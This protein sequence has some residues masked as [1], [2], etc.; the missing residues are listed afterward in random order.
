[1]YEFIKIQ[2]GRGKLTVD[3]VH[4]FVPKYI[5]EEQYMEIVGDADA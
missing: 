5:T 1:M 3:Q 2:F 4:A